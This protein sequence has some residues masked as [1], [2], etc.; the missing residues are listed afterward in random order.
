[1]D[2]IDVKIKCSND[3]LCAQFYQSGSNDKY[4]KC[5]AMAVVKT[6]KA[7]SVLYPKGIICTHSIIKLIIY[8]YFIVECVEILISCKYVIEFQMDTFYQRKNFVHQE[9]LQSIKR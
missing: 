2:P 5:D 7:G 8:T 3:F 9:N 1:M 6:S 4:Y